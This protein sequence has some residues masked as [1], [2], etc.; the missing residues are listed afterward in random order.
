MWKERHN[1]LF[2]FPVAIL[3]IPIPADSPLPECQWKR[4][5][6]QRWIA[7]TKF[8]LLLSNTLTSMKYFEVYFICW[9]LEFDLLFCFHL[10]T[11]LLI[12]FTIVSECCKSADWAVPDRF[13]RSLPGCNTLE[14]CSWA[15]DH[16][17]W[18]QGGKINIK[19]V[20]WKVIAIQGRK[21]NWNPLA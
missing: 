12:T 19:K 10:S 8:D 16:T 20:N 1:A 14:I 18:K 3:H 4:L 5:P 15:V 13:I 2:L 21:K 6:S 17:W 7:M 11:C 9:V